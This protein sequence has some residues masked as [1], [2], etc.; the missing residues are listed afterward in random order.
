MGAWSN[1]A[2]QA[3]QP[4]YEKIIAHPFVAELAAGT[5]SQERFRFYLRQDALYLAHYAE[6][7]AHTASRLGRRDF[8]AD[9]LRFASDGMAVEKALHESY[10]C[11][12]VPAPGEISPACMLY[13]SVLRAQATAPAEVEAAA[14]LPCFWVYRRVGEEILSRRSGDGNPYSRWIETYADPA[15]AASTDRAIEI[16]DA[17]ADAAGSRTRAL[18]T[19]IFVLCTRMEWMFWDSAYRL[20]TWRI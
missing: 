3:A 1:A 18:M 9:F 16:C 13:T 19:D 20:E 12:D 14:V 5:L 2:W 6:V 11:G 10:L 7:L 8:T 4:V 15:F 17:L